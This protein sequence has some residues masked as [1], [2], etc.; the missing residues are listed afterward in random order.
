LNI[1]QAPKITAIELALLVYEFGFGV[2]AFQNSHFDMRKRI[3][4]RGNHGAI[5]QEADKSSAVFPCNS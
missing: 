4:R 1:D 2:L 3:K 5:R